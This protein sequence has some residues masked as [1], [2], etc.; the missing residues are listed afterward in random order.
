MDEKNNEQ[1]YKSAKMMILDALDEKN[2]ESNI[3]GIPNSPTL[4][5]VGSLNVPIS[6]SEEKEVE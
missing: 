2:I 4:P 6:E 3:I 1:N 5:L